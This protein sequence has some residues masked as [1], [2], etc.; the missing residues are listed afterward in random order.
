MMVFQWYI[1][2]MNMDLSIMLMSDDYHAI[3]E[4]TA[5][6]QQHGGSGSRNMGGG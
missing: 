5:R 1:S 3:I 6:E 2:D 4:S